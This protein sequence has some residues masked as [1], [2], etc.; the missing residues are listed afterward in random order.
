MEQWLQT[1]GHALRVQWSKKRISG[2]LQA[3]NLWMK[4]PSAHTSL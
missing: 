1:T 3:A 4:K 2:K